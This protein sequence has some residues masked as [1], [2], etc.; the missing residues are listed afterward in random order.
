MEEF[1]KFPE[2]LEIKQMYE[3]ESGR[4]RRLVG[5]RISKLNE[6]NEIIV[7]VCQQTAG[8]LIQLRGKSAGITKFNVRIWNTNLWEGK[9]I[10]LK[11]ETESDLFPI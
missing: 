8:Q 7:E 1:L 2:V 3:K 10:K 6:I 9:K 5:G 4:M 11:R